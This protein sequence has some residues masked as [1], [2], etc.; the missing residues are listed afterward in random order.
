MLNYSSV[1]PASLL[2]ENLE[3]EEATAPVFLTVQKGWD[4][5]LPGF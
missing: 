4:R 3:P 2:L 1:L 5:C